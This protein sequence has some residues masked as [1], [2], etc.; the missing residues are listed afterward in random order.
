MHWVKENCQW[1]YQNVLETDWDAEHEE[2]CI[3]EVIEGALDRQ[4]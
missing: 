2:V 3:E 4:F 1:A